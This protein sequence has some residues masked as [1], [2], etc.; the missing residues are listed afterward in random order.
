MKTTH[1]PGPW[2]ITD[3]GYSI[4]GNDGGTLIVST[5]KSGW[6]HLAACSAQSGSSLAKDHFP[7][8]E[9]NA[10]L[11][12]AAPELLA[13]L[14]KVHGYGRA[15]IGH[16]QMCDYVSEVASEAIFKATGLRP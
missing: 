1:T 5:G 15:D 11:I 10:H 12:A 8:S 7:E 6:E 9:A 16:Q 3:D 4:V 14:R 13:A 2:N